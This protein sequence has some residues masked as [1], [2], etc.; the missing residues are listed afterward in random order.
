MSLISYISE[1]Q[2]RD[3]LYFG[4]KYGARFKN[5]IDQIV[6]VMTISIFDKVIYH[7]GVLKQCDIDGIIVGSKK[8][9]PHEV[10]NMRLGDEI[11]NIKLN[12]KEKIEHV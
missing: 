2:D 9:E 6:T 10:M 1:K 5:C 4:Q 7:I 11:K 3:N 8:F 12:R